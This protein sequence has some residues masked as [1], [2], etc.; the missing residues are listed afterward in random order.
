MSKTQELLPSINTRY[1]SILLRRSRGDTP[2]RE[3]A[4]KTGISAGTLSRVERRVGV[5]TFETVARLASWFELPLGRLICRYKP[6]G[7]LMSYEMDPENAVMLFMNT[8]E[9]AEFRF[10][11]IPDDAVVV[12]SLDACCVHGFQTVGIGADR[13]SAFKDAVRHAFAM[14]I[15]DMDLAECPALKED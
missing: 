4:T 12:C 9:G 2:L 3:L 15:E 1:L 13:E 14:I 8:L 6:M 7:E 10:T 5:P 11:E